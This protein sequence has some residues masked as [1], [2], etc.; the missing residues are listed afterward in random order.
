[1][2][3]ELITTSYLT[4]TVLTCIV[5]YLVVQLLRRKRYKL[6]PGPKGWPII[7]SYLTLTSGKYELRDLLNMWAK[8]YGDLYMFSMFGSRFVILNSY[9]LVHEAFQS[10]DFNDRAPI[11]PCNKALN[12]SNTARIRPFLDQSACEHAVRALVSSRIDYANSLLCGTSALNVKRLQRAQNRAAKLVFRAKKYDHVTPFL[13]QLHWL[14]VEKR[15]TY[16]ILTITYKCLNNSAPNYLTKLLPNEGHLWKEQRS[17]VTQ[18]LRN[19]K[20]HN[21]NFEDLV[22]AEAAKLI[23]NFA[24]QEGTFF[25]P[26]TDIDVT[27]SNVITGIL[28]GKTY[29]YNDEE[30]VELTKRA[31]QVFEWM[32]PGSFFYHVPVLAYMPMEINKMGDAAAKGMFDFLEKILKRHRQAYNPEDEPKDLIEAF[33]HEEANKKAQVRVEPRIF[34]KFVSKYFFVERILYSC[35]QLNLLFKL[36]INVDVGSF[37]HQCLKQVVWDLMLGGID[38][39]STSLSWYFLFMAQYPDVQAKV[40]AELDKVIGRDRLPSLS[41]RQNLPFTESTSV[42]CYRFCRLINVQIPHRTRCDVKLG[43][44]DIPKGTNVGTNASWLSSSPS[45]WENSEEFVPDRFIDKETGLYNSKLEAG[46]VEF[47]VGRRVCPGEQ[48]ARTELFV[49]FTHILHRF[50]LRLPEGTPITRDGINGLT[51][52]PKPY[53]ITAAPRR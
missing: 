30:F 29:D 11:L 34:F 28:T 53:K 45:L 35:R 49:I 3:T 9:D 33:L 21:S 10:P 6:P 16:K 20:Q 41:D 4:T 19:V 8:E 50:T 7:G 31:Q 13:Q 43:G 40:Q 48:L 32:G 39:V 25:N 18:Y 42:E 2:I 52:H 26:I 51:H 27:V 22:A 14:P 38:S 44:Y 23:K 17:F 47:G 24:S 37:T 1:M 5:G 46:L 15:I 36:R 12:R